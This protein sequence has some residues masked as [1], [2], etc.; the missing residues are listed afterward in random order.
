MS[1]FDQLID[2]TGLET[3]KQAYTPD[4]INTSGHISM[5]GAEFEF[6]TAPFVTEA[7]AEWAKKGLYGYTVPT[8]D[9]WQCIADWM[10][11]HRNWQIR[12]DWIVPVYGITS[13]VATTMRAFTEEGDGIIGFSPGYHMYWEA[14]EWS[15][16]RKVPSPLLYENGT[17]RI[18]W[19]DLEAKM[20]DPRN[21]ILLVCNPNNPTGTVYS[22]EDLRRIAELAVKYDVILYNDEI[23][24]ECL[25]DGVEF[26]TFNQVAG[27]DLKVITATSIGKWLSFTGANQANLIIPNDEL[28]EAFIAERNREFYGSYQPPLIPAT[29]AAYTPEGE[30][31]LSEMMAYV[32]ENYRM[33][34]AFFREYLPE[35]RAVKPDG[36]YILWVDAQDFC[37]RQFGGDDAKFEDFLVNKAYF[38]MDIGTRYGDE[39]GFFRMALCIPRA[40]LRRNLESLRTAV[41]ELQK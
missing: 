24:A 9:F 35:F 23:F 13:S 11:F 8:E 19:E 10:D 28:R 16:R 2:R 37:G 3:V 31:W 4:V 40:E 14:V 26:K 32:Q 41:G 18:D 5:W 30:R 36:T 17:F 20:A 1:H 29:R 12:T 7:L 39:T 27:N 25:Y 34:D 38:H 33:V 15:N 22:P 21:K 6:P